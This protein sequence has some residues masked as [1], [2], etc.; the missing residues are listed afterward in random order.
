MSRRK[1]GKR[2]GP[3]GGGQNQNQG[4]TQTTQA[5]HESPL[6]RGQSAESQPRVIQA[7]RPQPGKGQVAVQSVMTPRKNIFKRAMQPRN[8][9][10]AQKR[11]GLVFYET[12]QSA[13][14][15]IPRL[16]DI[17]S[18][19]DQLNIVIRAESP[20]DDPELNQI[21]KVFAGAAWALIHERRKQDGWYDQ[22]HE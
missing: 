17:A 12:L 14:M 18:Q 9:S 21:G 13:K 10:S 20:M 5:P 1:R 2:R 6:Q 11:Y 15:D 7:E 3:G 22:P 16:K 8:A 4:R 19:C